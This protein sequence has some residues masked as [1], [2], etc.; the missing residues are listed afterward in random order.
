MQAA[1][2][3][4]DRSA[5]PDETEGKA[6]THCSLMGTT[7]KSCSK[8]S[9]LLV[10]FLTVACASI[11]L[12]SA[13]RK[14]LVSFGRES[15]GDDL[16]S[17]SHV[18][19]AARLLARLLRELLVEEGV[20]HVDPGRQPLGIVRNASR[21]LRIAKL[22]VDV[23]VHRES[24]SRLCANKMEL[25]D[26]LEPELDERVV[27]ELAILESLGVAVRDGDDARGLPDRVDEDAVRGLNVSAH[28]QWQR[29]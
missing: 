20:E 28:T 8:M 11:F 7:T 24:A 21:L 13:R 29:V 2:K 14:M 26:A 3:E 9:I 4:G 19:L 15:L 1:K 16:T 17:D 5:S 10:H 12:R 27:E 22:A 23:S 6:E 18:V 25:V